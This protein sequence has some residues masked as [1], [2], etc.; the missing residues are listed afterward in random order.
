MNTAS[1][2]Y[3]I[4]Q[5]TQS[6]ILAAPLTNSQ[7]FQSIASIKLVLASCFGLS[8]SLKN[9]HNNTGGH[10]TVT[11]S[12]ARLLQCIS[13]SNSLVRLFGS[14]VQNHITNTMDQGLFCGLFCIELVDAFQQSNHHRH[15]VVDIFEVILAD[16]LNYLNLDYCFCKLRLDFSNTRHIIKLVKSV[17]STKPGCGF[18]NVDIN[19]IS[20]IIIDT[21]LESAISNTTDSMASSVHYILLEGFKITDT[22]VVSGLLYEIPQMSSCMKKMLKHGIGKDITSSFSKQTTIKVFLLDTSMAGDNSNYLDVTYQTEDDLVFSNVT[23]SKIMQ[24]M[25]CMVQKHKVSINII[26][27]LLYSP[28]PIRVWGGGGVYWILLVDMSVR[29]SVRASEPGLGAIFVVCQW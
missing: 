8:G 21:F 5:K 27:T 28:R 26:Q 16:L 20:K 13:Y 22:H 25:Q 18:S 3:C 7:W 15:L 17:I 23:L 9:I 19:Y 11:S 6:Q 12:S 14:S 10:I 29:L 24:L 4:A 1:K 2:E